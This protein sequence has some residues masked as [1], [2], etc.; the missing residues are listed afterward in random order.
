MKQK[1][2][3][4]PSWYPTPNNAFFGSNYKYLFLA[5]DSFYEV[6]F[7]QGIEKKIGIAKWGFSFFSRKVSYFDTITPPRGIGFYFDQ[8]K[9]PYFLQI[10]EPINA[11]FEK[12]NYVLMGKAYI[13]EINKL[14]DNGW[15]PDLMHALST[16]HAGIATFY[17]SKKTKIPYVIS[18]HQVFLPAILFTI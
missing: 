16:V 5:M 10:I 18:E 15:K 6:S 12:L 14:I 1:L 13:R 2:L 8:I 17:L 9:V 3:F 7:L 11:R 4:L